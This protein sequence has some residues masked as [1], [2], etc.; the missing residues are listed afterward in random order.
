MG[1]NPCDQKLIDDQMIELDG[2]KNKSKV[3]AMEF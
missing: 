1:L 2:T 3:G